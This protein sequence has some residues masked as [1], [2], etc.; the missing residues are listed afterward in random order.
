MA[1]EDITNIKIDYHKVTI[2]LVSGEQIESRSTWGKEN[3]VLKLD[4]DCFTHSA[5]KKNKSE[6]N[7]EARGREA[8]FNKKFGSLSNFKI[9]K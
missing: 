7:A 8:K 5:W 3:S 4:T 1:K 6:R 9:S 2:Q